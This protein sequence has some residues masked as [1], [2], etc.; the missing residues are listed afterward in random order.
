VIKSLRKH[1]DAFLDCHL[2][3]SE[4]AKWVSDFAKAGASQFTFHIEA[5]GMALI[6]LCMPCDT[7]DVGLTICVENQRILRV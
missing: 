2:M 3:V 1:T 4:P 6:A 5:T 7:R